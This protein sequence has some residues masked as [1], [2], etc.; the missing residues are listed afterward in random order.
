MTPHPN[1]CYIAPWNLSTRSVYLRGLCKWKGLSAF[2]I[3][4]RI[5]SWRGPETCPGEIHT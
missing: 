2:V 3:W 4:S 1:C 5:D